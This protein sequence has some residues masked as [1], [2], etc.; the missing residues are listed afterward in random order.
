MGRAVRWVSIPLMTV[1]VASIATAAT[2]QGDATES[3]HRAAYCLEAS[4][5]YSTRLLELVT[6]LK[7]SINN[8]EAMLAD[9]RFSRTDKSQPSTKLAAMRDSLSK[10]EADRERWS[11]NVVVFMEHMTKRGLLEAPRE[12]LKSE[13]DKVRE[14]ENA[15]HAIYRSCLKRCIPDD[16]KCRFACND[17]ANDSEPSKRMLA[18]GDVVHR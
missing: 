18:C 8:G 7:D 10:S 14:D 12:V 1:I 3:D 15:V 5:S 13:G 9:S 11:A 4:F 16:D 2:A 17:E 6:V